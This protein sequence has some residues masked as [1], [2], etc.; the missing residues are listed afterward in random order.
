MPVLAEMQKVKPLVK[1]QE[2]RVADNHIGDI[3]VGHDGIFFF[4]YELPHMPAW[5]EMSIMQDG[6]VIVDGEPIA[7][8]VFDVYADKYKEHCDEINC[9]FCKKYGFNCYHVMIDYMLFLTKRPT[10]YMTFKEV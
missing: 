4:L 3:T 9:T 7:L 6:H 5:K 10:V 1:W 8:H 2:I